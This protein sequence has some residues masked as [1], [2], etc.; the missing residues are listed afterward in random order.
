MQHIQTLRDSRC[1]KDMRLQKEILH[2]TSPLSL[3]LSRYLLSIEYGL[4]LIQ[5]INNSFN[6]THGK[7]SIHVHMHF[8][9][10]E[11][12]ISSRQCTVILSLRVVPPLAIGLRSNSS[13]AQLKGNRVV[14]KNGSG[15][16]LC[17]GNYR[18]IVQPTSSP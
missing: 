1:A 13:T 8:G 9:G 10:R 17:G 12:F 5:M 18:L 2:F 11:G 4:F 7:D 15:K 16:E 3:S 14:L 6:Y